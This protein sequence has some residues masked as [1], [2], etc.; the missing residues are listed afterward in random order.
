[1]SLLLFLKADS[2][3][4]FVSVNDGDKQLAAK[5]W[6]AGRELSNQLL[7]TISELCESAG[8][9]IDDF[10]GIVVYQGPGS[11]T[12]LRISISAAN[13][14]GYSLNIPVAGSSGDDWIARSSEVL[15][16]T[17][18]FKPVSPIYGGDVYTTKP[19]K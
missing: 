13:A 6:Q 12:G 19:K 4:V 3:D 5:D 17:K 14:L 2:E 7:S 16:R 9:T 15:S 10:D 18:I 8:K 1:M 11:Y